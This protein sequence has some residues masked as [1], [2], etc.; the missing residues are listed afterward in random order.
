MGIRRKGG[1]T[2]V[3]DGEVIAL[4]SHSHSRDDKLPLGMGS[5]TRFYPWKQRAI[6]GSALETKSMYAFCGRWDVYRIAAE[7]LSGP[8]RFLLLS[9]PQNHTAGKKR[10][11]ENVSY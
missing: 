5:Y 4:G 7:N 9:E 8:R 11:T 1:I 3:D 10:E 2:A 6:E